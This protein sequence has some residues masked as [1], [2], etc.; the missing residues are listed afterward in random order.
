MS[1]SLPVFIL[2]VVGLSNVTQK[3]DWTE[4][5]SIFGCEYIDLHHLRLN[6]RYVDYFV[7][8]QLFTVVETLG[9]TGGVES[10]E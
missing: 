6:R 8:N 10:H 5:N 7:I 3:S 1:L 9:S 2:Q 4:I